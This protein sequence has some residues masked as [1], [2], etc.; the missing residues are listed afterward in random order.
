MNDTVNIN[1][2]S[3]EL[4]AL[5]KKELETK[6]SGLP[7]THIHMLLDRSGSMDS[8]KS[9]TIGGINQFLRDQKA[10]PGKCTFTLV[11][12]DSQAPYEVV[13]SFVPIVE[14]AELNTATYVPRGGTPLL[15]A[16]GKALN[17]VAAK[18]DSMTEPPTRVVFVIITD[19]QENESKE[20]TKA[21]IV[22]KLANADKR[23]WQVQYLGVGIDAI[24]DA[25]QLG[26]RAAS[27]LNIGAS[28]KGVNCA[29]A[30]VSRSMLS[31]RGGGDASV[32]NFTG[33]DRSVQQ[34]EGAVP[35]TTGTV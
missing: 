11:Q 22:T 21:M 24:G 33:E 10:A 7:Y 30:A 19:G 23:G 5:V 28:T 12:F 13:Q 17:D 3:P 2:L 25:T 29:Y 35:T 8:L 27:T 26:V 31:Y 14:A 20:F 1:Q 32:L 15:D 18:V 6:A 34:A 16:I 4:Q 9:D